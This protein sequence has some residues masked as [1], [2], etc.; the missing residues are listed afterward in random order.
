MAHIM[1]TAQEVLTQW[2]LVWRN[3]LAFFYA[4]PCLTA[5]LTEMCPLCSH[6]Y[7]QFTSR[8]EP[9]ELGLPEIKLLL[10]D[11]DAK[12]AHALG[13]SKMSFLPTTRKGKGAGFDS[14]GRLPTQKVRLLQIFL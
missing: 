9:I 13:A 10:A 7:L 4:G 8:E 3:P 1:D 12:L 11:L 6:C 14:I 2:S 5:M